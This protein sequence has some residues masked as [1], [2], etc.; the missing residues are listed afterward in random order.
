LRHALADAATA[1]LRLTYG[2]AGTA[3]TL[4]EVSAATDNVTIST[5][6]AN[7]LRIHL[8]GSTFD[9]GST[10]AAPGLTYEVAGDPGHS[11]FAAIDISSGNVITTLTVNLGDNDDT[12]TIGSTVAAGRIGSILVDGQGGV[13]TSTAATDN[14]SITAGR[15]VFFNIASGITVAD[16][17]VTID[18]DPGAFVAGNFEGVL[19]IQGRGGNLLLP[20]LGADGVRIQTGAAIMAMW[21]RAPP[22]VSSW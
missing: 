10:A 18:A 1:A 17:N 9:A 21:L 8:N 11:T 19:L 20:L 2:G 5:P 6:D 14:V 15:N 7:T 4:S 22:R 16:G 13:D 12:L 3:L